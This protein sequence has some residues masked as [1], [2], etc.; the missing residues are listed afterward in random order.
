MQSCS[1][2]VEAEAEDAKALGACRSGSDPGLCL[3]S[4]S[5]GGSAAAITHLGYNAMLQQAA[6][7]SNPS[8]QALG[9]RL[10]LLAEITNP[11]PLLLTSILAI[12]FNPNPA[13]SLHYTIARTRDRVASAHW[14]TVTA[15]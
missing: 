15:T 1:L 2:L 11:L 7:P 12:P 8:G 14:S 3:V 6:E 9:A 10:S 13:D 5:H 4:T